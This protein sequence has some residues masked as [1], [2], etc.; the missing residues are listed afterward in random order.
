M[1][2]KTNLKNF[3]SKGQK[4]EKYAKIILLPLLGVIFSNLFL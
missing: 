1:G 2:G 3:I 4:T